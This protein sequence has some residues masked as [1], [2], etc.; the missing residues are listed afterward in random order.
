MTRIIQISDTHLSPGKTHF[1]GN[2]A[3][4]AA[5][6]RAQRPDLVIHTGDLTIDGADK[7]ED[8]V[9]C[10]AQLREL[11]VPFRVVPG[12]HDVGDSNHRHQPVNTDRLARWERFI[13]PERWVEDI[14]GWRLIGL[15][16]MLIGSNHEREAEQ[17]AWAEAAMAAADGRRLA[18]FLHRPLFLSAPDEADTGYWSMKPQPRRDWL[19][20]VRRHDIG[21]VASGHLHRAHDF[22]VDGARYVWGPSS[23]FL[24][25]PAV[26]PEMPGEKSLG[27]VLYE[28]NGGDVRVE[29]VAVPGLAEHWIDNIL[30][31][32]Y[33]RHTDTRPAPR[34]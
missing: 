17:L 26:Q 34:Q 25:G 30:E 23:A 19:D 29:I 4:L 24:C 18:C 9:Y 12:N 21:L 28:F 1:N 13:G 22:T 11:G 3:P 16:A 32:V 14:A 27:A 15:D 20:L 6:V 2:W 8:L 5:W 31:E 33:P 10:A 7:D